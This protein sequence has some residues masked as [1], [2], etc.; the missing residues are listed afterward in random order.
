MNVKT[1]ILSGKI[2]TPLGEMLACVSDEGLHLLEFT[3]RKKYDRQINGLKKYFN[4]EIIKGK[5]ALHK[6][7]QNQMSEY[8]SGKLKVF[9]IPL[10]FSGTD[11]QKNV[12]NALSEIPYGKTVS[13]SDIAKRINNPKAVRAV[14]NANAANKIAI[15]VPCHRVTGKNGT[16]TG[17]AS[18][19]DKKEFLLNI[20]KNV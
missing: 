20:E 7:V 14:A 13:Y 10:I 2:N 5:H 12:W 6:E 17:Y 16:L 9:K 1:K 15:I 11:F 18:G 4:T 19:L 8:F 3:D